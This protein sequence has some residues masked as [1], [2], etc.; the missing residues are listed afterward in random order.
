MPEEDNADKSP[1][2]EPRDPAAFDGK[3]W[4][5]CDLVKFANLGVELPITL[6]VGGLIISGQLTSGR[7]YF[8][9]MSQKIKSEQD[10]EILAAVRESFELNAKVYEIPE[11]PAEDWKLP[12]PDYVHLRNAKVYTNER[13]PLPDGDA[14]AWRG[15]LTAVDGYWLGYLTVERE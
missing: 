11:E 8:E 9:Q 4:F 10:D 3:D 2:A 5:L 13:R 7:I 12:T 15:K 6:N 1:A 14:V